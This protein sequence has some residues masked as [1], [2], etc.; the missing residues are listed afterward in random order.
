MVKPLGAE[1]SWPFFYAWVWVQTSHHP[2]QLLSHVAVPRLLLADLG[3][4]LSFADSMVAAPL[5]EDDVPYLHLV[6]QFVDLQDFRFGEAG[7]SIDFRWAQFIRDLV[8]AVRLFAVANFGLFHG[9]VTAVAPVFDPFLVN[10]A[11]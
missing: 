10:E 8:A 4:S 3:E 1:S 11:F 7:G 6:V 2:A 9:L 5:A